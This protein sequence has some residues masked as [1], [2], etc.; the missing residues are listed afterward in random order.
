[1][2]APLDHPRNALKIILK[3][4]ILKFKSLTDTIAIG[5]KDAAC[6]DAVAGKYRHRNRGFLVTFDPSKVT[7]A[8]TSDISKSPHYEAVT[9][10]GVIT[11]SRLSYA[12]S[13]SDTPNL[14]AC[15]KQSLLIS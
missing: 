2:M 10:T 13:A 5:G 3:N 1:M 9:K 6:S 4:T 11:L 8:Y 12:C 7:N 14:L 15:T